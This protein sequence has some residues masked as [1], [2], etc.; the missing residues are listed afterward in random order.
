[1]RGGSGRAE[2]P[3][4][5]GG[6]TQC[7]RCGWRL[8][9]SDHFCSLC[10]TR[11]REL[12]VEPHT[13]V[14]PPLDSVAR[15]ARE[16]GPEPVSPGGFDVRNRGKHA[17]HLLAIEPPPGIDIAPPVPAGEDGGLELPV[18][19]ALT[20]EARRAEE[21]ADDPRILLRTSIGALRLPIRTEPS[22]PLRLS[23]RSFRVPRDQQADVECELS[24]AWGAEW[25]TLTAHGEGLELEEPR[26]R[27]RLQAGLPLPVRLRADAARCVRL[28]EGCRLEVRLD[29]GAAFVFSLVFEEAVPGRLVWLSATQYLAIRVFPGESTQVIVPLRN[30]GLLD[31]R[32]EAVSLTEQGTDRELPGV[33]WR[34]LDA[35]EQPLSLPCDVLPGAVIH[36]RLACQGSPLGVRRGLLRLAADDAQPFRLNLVIDATEPRQHPFPVAL[37]FGTTASAVATDPAPQRPGRPTSIEFRSGD[38]RRSNSYLPSDVEIVRHPAGAGIAFEIDW[39]EPSEA[40]HLDYA[41]NLK[42]RLGL[43]EEHGDGIQRVVLDGQVVDVEVEDLAEFVVREMKRQ[44][45]HR[46]ERRLERVIATFPTRFSLRRIDA[47]RETYRRAGLGNVVL[48]D[49]AMAAGILGMYNEFIDQPEY[50]MLVYDMGGGTTDV[51]LFHVVN[52]RERDGFVRIEPTVLGVAG[53]PQLGGR[54][55]TELMI[56][57]FFESLPAEDRLAIPW[58]GEHLDHPELG[59]LARRNQNL[60]FLEAEQVKL[61]L[62]STDSQLEAGSDTLRAAL[63][64]P[65]GTRFLREMTYT[66]QAVLD[67]FQPRLERLWREI[68]DMVRSSGA[69]LDFLY[70]AGRGSLLPSVRH[71]LPQWLATGGGFPKLQTVLA[72]NQHGEV[73]LKEA[74]SLG[75]ALAIDL[76]EGR[77]EHAALIPPR[78]LSA[79]RYGFRFRQGFREILPVNSPVG[80]PSQ[81]RV[82]VRLTNP[83]RPDVYEARLEVWESPTRAILADDP[84][85]ELVGF[86]HLTY[87]ADEI[88]PDDLEAQVGLKLHEDRTLKLLAWRGDQLK[89]VPVNR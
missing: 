32:V 68:L 44:A 23:A 47:L 10:G 6:G 67:A 31:Y 62:F 21:V 35:R 85:A 60:L 70:L 45:E 77:D 78:A 46:L 82:P 41:R 50:T 19:G 71:G 87:S 72:Q 30:E 29:D 27:V 16:D 39:G 38:G 89:E 28:E 63:E 7:D 3:P 22:P 86:G 9:D 42:R 64:L 5:P 24:L 8:E 34:L 14:L 36:V 55:V 48:I 88:G 52:R 56:R 79:S 1:M 40:R 15:E 75:A 59:R 69:S 58:P 49:E 33:E 13:L 43:G 65:G 83:Y 66:P 17:I 61:R 2:A 84:E 76:I 80:E 81:I 54:D 73:V 51:T 74:V 37:D 53:D 57:Q 25:V 4:V 12:V 20:F 11:Q 18:G 26:S